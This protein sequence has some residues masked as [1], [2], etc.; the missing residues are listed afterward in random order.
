MPVEYLT[1]NICDRMFFTNFCDANSI[2]GVFLLF[3]IQDHFI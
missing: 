3:F 1:R 2:F